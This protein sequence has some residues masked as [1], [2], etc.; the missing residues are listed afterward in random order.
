MW[1]LVCL[2]CLGTIHRVVGKRSELPKGMPLAACL[3]ASSRANKRS[4]RV[5]L[6]GILDCKSCRNRAPCPREHRA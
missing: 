4:K 5:K 1:C 3:L 2:Q 6:N